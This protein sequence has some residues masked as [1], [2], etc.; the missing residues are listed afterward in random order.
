MTDGEPKIDDIV[1]YK[2]K[3]ETNDGVI[4]IIIHIGLIVDQGFMLHNTPNPKILSKWNIAGEDIHAVM[5]VPKE[6]INLN[7]FP[8]YWTNVP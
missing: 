2:Y 6:F 4:D 7:C 3:R 5:D 1:L 8:E